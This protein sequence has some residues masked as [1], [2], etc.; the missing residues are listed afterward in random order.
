MQIRIILS[1]PKIFSCIRILPITVESLE[2][3]LPLHG[4]Y[5]NTYRVQLRY[6][7]KYYILVRRATPMKDSYTYEVRV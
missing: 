2:V 6:I 4:T 1:D 5:A 7:Y 3:H